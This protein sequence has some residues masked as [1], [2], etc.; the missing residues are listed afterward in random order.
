LFDL[1]SLEYRKSELDLLDNGG[2][3]YFFLGE[4][5]GQSDI[6]DNRV[7]YA[8]NE[9]CTTLVQTELPDSS[10]FLQNVRGTSFP[11]YC[12]KSR[13][14]ISLPLPSDL[15]KTHKTY[16][17]TEELWFGYLWTNQKGG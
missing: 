6:R 17:E 7:I 9:A 8:K 1:S 13:Y 2:M 15:E 11:S 10:D 5:D 12:L 3:I 4:D 16:L 14:R